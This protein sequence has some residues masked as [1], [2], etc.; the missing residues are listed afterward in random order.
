MSLVS[1][2]AVYAA[3][4]NSATIANLGSNTIADGATINALE[5]SLQSPINITNN[6]QA[7]SV[8]PANTHTV[9]DVCPVIE[10]V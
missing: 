1:T 10:L 3:L 6:K 2:D 7:K 4:L 9:R 8:D 5:N